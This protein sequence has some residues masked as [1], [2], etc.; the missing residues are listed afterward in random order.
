MGKTYDIADNLVKS[1]CSLKY[2]DYD[3]K[4]KIIQYAGKLITDEFGSTCLYMQKLGL[5]VFSPKDSAVLSGM[6][7]SEAQIKQTVFES[8]VEKLVELLEAVRDSIGGT[9]EGGDKII[10]IQ[11]RDSI[12]TS[13]IKSH[14]KAK[15]YDP[16][17]IKDSDDWLGILNDLL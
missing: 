13:R 3:A 5:I 1:A 2:D 16:V 14:I 15:G 4:D 6:G 12:S 9:L 17:V 7:A 11:T 10:V 8:G